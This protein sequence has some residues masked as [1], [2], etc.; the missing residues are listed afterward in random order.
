MVKEYLGK[1]LHVVSPRHRHPQRPE[2][3][4]TR[5][6]DYLTKFRRGDVKDRRDPAKLSQRFPQP[7]LPKNPKGYDIVL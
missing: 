2:A 1:P 4:V 7:H 3:P 5:Y 6:I